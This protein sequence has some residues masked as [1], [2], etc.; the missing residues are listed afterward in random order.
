M[1][2]VRFPVPRQNQLQI[3]FPASHLNGTRFPVIRI[4]VHGE[5]LVILPFHVK[6][7]FSRTIVKP[8]G[9]LAVTQI[10]A[11]FGD[12]LRPFSG[13]G[14]AQ[15]HLAHA[16]H[17]VNLHL[18]GT[19]RPALQNG[20]LVRILAPRIH[21][22]GIVHLDAHRN[23][24]GIADQ[25]HHP[26][27]HHLLTP[28]QQLHGSRS[29]HHEPVLPMVGIGDI[30]KVRRNHLTADIVHRRILQAVQDIRGTV[31]DGKD[32]GFG[33]VRLR[34]EDPIVHLVGGELDT[35]HITLPLAGLLAHMVSGRRG[36]VTTRIKIE[37]HPGNDVFVV[38]V[39]SARHTAGSRLGGI[40]SFQTRY[41]EFNHRPV[42]LRLPPF[43]PAGRKQQKS[44]RQ[45]I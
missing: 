41:A 19:R 23:L 31:G 18:L 6:I 34:R 17:Q 42:P 22:H 39:F 14:T 5:C 20:I 16:V 28:A 11:F 29:A 36:S 37:I 21:I 13:N 12:H 8:H 38:A 32:R 26:L 9:I 1:L 33:N 7:E 27:R 25:A 43:L 10:I 24:G 40:R 2:Q 45:R 44:R 15:G 4:G 3:R 35:E 30:H